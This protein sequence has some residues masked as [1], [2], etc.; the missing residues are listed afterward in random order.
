MDANGYARKF[1]AL[2]HFF[3]LH[4]FAAD[5]LHLSLLKSGKPCS[6]SGRKFVCFSNERQQMSQISKTF[7]MKYLCH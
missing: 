7:Q 4:V 3:L 5:V 6:A 1:K 2:H